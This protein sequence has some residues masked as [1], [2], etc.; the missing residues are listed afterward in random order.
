[1]LDAFVEAVITRKQP[2]D[3]VEEAYYASA[4]SLLGHEAIEAG[5]ILEFPDEY[6]IDYL[7][8]SAPAIIK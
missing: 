4:L 3:I 8:H 7:N 2:K 5:R 6:K 1:M